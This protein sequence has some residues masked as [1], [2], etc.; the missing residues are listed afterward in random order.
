M[1]L[2]LILRNPNGLTDLG[3]INAEPAASKK[4][5]VSCMSR[6]A[7]RKETMSFGLSELNE[8]MM[9]LRSVLSSEGSMM[10]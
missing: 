7:M 8:S 1:V 2:N 9:S 4:V 3:P 6:L 5:F 10:W